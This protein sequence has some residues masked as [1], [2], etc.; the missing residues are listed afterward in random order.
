MTLT[1]IC[2]QHA[3][4]V[5]HADNN[6]MVCTHTYIH[7]YLWQQR[8]LSLT[9]AKNLCTLCYLLKKKICIKIGSTLAGLKLWKLFALPK[10]FQPMNDSEIYNSLEDD[11]KRQWLF[12]YKNFTLD[13]RIALAHHGWRVVHCYVD[14]WPFW[15][16]PLAF[17]NFGLAQD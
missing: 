11:W 4:F 3:E 9:S 15:L 16:T 14:F 10:K 17:S 8:K 13:H 12:Q 5:F 1:G 2:I 7:M 6:V